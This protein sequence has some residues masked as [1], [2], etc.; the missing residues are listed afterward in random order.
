MCRVAVL[1]AAYNGKKWIGE[2]IRTIQNQIDVS[3][4]IYISV[5][6]SDD[7]TEDIVEFLANTHP[8]IIA[9]PY[10][11]KFGGAA[12]NFYRLLKEVDFSSFDFVSLSDQDDIWHSDKLTRA[13]SFL[14]NGYDFY[15]SNVNAFWPDG[16]VH[17]INKSQP[18]VQF[19]HFFEAAGPGCTYVFSQSA[20]TKIQSFI[21]DNETLVSLI[22]LH[23]WFIYA[24]ARCHHYSW[25]IDKLP[26]MEY[27]QHGSNQVGANVS[28][29]AAFKRIKLI[30]NKWYRNEV[31]K[32]NNVLGA[33]SCDFMKKALD[34]G[35]KGN[36]FLMKN[37]A[38]IRRRQR[39][40]IMLFVMCL[41]NWF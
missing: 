32:I 28:L 1:L 13:I 11:Y 35:Y 26:S 29:P 20:A 10:G 39:D 3:V 27:R 40:R 24:Y 41:F 16:R 8:D 25:Y 22:S 34:N 2:Q 18:Q 19:D 37:I 31:V 7:S 17:L 23:D 33:N 6:C 21:N 38:S 15:S 12:K 36:L 14:K 4:T 5:D 9:L 30:K